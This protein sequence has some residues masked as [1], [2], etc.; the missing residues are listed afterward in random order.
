M[1]V[2]NANN[3]LDLTVDGAAVSITLDPNLVY[4]AATLASAIQ[5]SINA[6]LPA[7]TS[8]VVSQ[9]SGVLSINSD[10]YG[11]SSAV[12]LTGG[13][14][15]SNLFGVQTETAGS[16]DGKMVITSSRYGSASSV[17]VS[18][19]AATNLTGVGVA[20][21]GT[22]VAGTIGGATA[23]GSG[24]YLT[25][26]G[27]AMGLRLL[28]SAT[29][30]GDHGVVN[31]SQGFAYQLNALTTSFLDSTTGTF[32]SETDGINASI[33]DIDTRRTELQARLVDIEARYRAQF[34]ALDTLIASMQSTQSFL[35]QQL[36]SLSA[37]ANY[38]VTGGK[39]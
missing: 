15:L 39:A 4:T 36:S 33:K 16:G 23:T 35:T 1:P 10:S 28:I 22:D 7:G 6:A 8:V 37:L 18:G 14:G 26:T 13:S 12:N 5:T 20:T 31:F 19:S 21:A 34:N 32:V 25:G 17:S 9:S 24:Q 29:T 38:S 11:A 30:A 2:T 27:N 3:T